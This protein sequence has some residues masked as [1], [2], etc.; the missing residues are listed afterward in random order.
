MH[1][2]QPGGVGPGLAA[3]LHQLDNL[4]LLLG[5]KLGASAPDPNAVELGQI[6]V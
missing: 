4:F 6:P 5:G 3:R 2:K 1:P